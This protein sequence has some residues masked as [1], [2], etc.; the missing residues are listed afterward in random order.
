M[1][2]PEL[3][4]SRALRVRGLRFETQYRDAPGT[5]DLAFPDRRLAVFVDGDLWHGHPQR[6]IPDY[7]RRKIDRNRDH[8]A[9]INYLLERD[10]WTVLRFWE[11]DIRR[12][13]DAC[14]EAVTRSL[15]V[16]S[17]GAV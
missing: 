12:N 7:W 3:A 6:R 2:G 16:T 4:L 14:V 5:P 1:T 17:A 15:G 11:R 13:L 10:G 8:D 9:W